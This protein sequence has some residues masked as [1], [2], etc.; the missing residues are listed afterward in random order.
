[1]ILGA[2]GYGDCVEIKFACPTCDQHL[3][4]SD[5][6][7]GK[8]V[9]CP[10]C[11]GR[12]QIPEGFGGAATE[13]SDA[14]EPKVR[15]SSHQW[16]DQSTVPMWQAAAIGLGCTLLF[17]LLVLPLRGTAFGAK[18][19][20]RGA[21]PYVLVFLAGICVGILVIKYLRLRRQRQALMLDVLPTSIAETISSNTLP[22][23]IEHVNGLSP[24]LNNS[25]MVNRIRRGLEHFYVRRSNPEVAAM[26][27][28][29]S[30]IDATAIQSSFTMIR[31]FIW[32][33]PILGFIGTVMGM[34]KAIAGISGGG[35]LNLDEMLASINTMTGGLG[36]A[37]DTTLI[38]LV[39]SL[40]ISVPANALQK[41]EEDLLNQIDDHCNENLLKRLDDG[42][43]LN[44]VVLNTESMAKAMHEVLT[45]GQGQV[46][47]YLVDLEKRMTELHAQHLELMER[48]R[49]EMDLHLLRMQALVNDQTELSKGT[50][51]RTAEAI[52][53]EGREAIQQ[54]SANLRREFDG[55]AGALQR[56][57]EVLGQLGGQQVV[58]QQVAPPPAP[59][60]RP[61]K[62]KGWFGR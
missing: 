22:A 12:I 37:F 33:I 14:G 61:A 42:G 29:Q 2:T 32:A 36:E 11:D 7:I 41:N 48:S 44:E 27:E 39:L 35:E 58:V 9:R 49:A 20:S 13:A 6:M 62:R 50:L 31:V 1:M 25:F 16:S 54:A 34:S 40:L 5:D 19:V 52:E 56:L 60:A 46:L 3:T 55:M 10:S 30:D 26:M 18:F 8:V 4:S 21:V 51:T 45:D 57:N 24:R 53:T 17:Y 43:G 47:E 28:S 38:A 23:F 15:F 59:S